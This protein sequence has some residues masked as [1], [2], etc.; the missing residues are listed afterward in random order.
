MS[1]KNTTIFSKKIFFSMVFLSLI[2]LALSVSS[3]QIAYDNG[4]K[5]TDL[6]VSNNA[7]AVKIT[8]ERTGELTSIDAYL[9]RSGG[10]YFDGFVWAYAMNSSHVAKSANLVSVPNTGAYSWKNYDAIPNFENSSDFYVGIGKLMP[11]AAIT[12]GSDTDSPSGRSETSNSMFDPSSYVIDNSN[13]YMIRANFHYYPTVSNIAITPNPTN[14]NPL[15]TA[16]C[17]AY[18]STVKKAHYSVDNGADWIA[19]NPTDGTW[20]NATEEINAIIPTGTL[21]DGSHNIEIRCRDNDNYFTKPL[22]STSFFIDRVNPNTTISFAPPTPNGNGWYNSPVVFNLSATD[23]EPSSGIAYSEYLLFG[24]T[25]Q[26]WTKETTRTISNNGTTRIVY[27][28]AD[29]AGNIESIAGHVSQ[30]SIDQI[31][32]ST[33]ILNPFPNDY[34]NGTSQTVSWTASTDLPSGI[35]YYNIY[36]EINETGTF[37]LLASTTDTWYID[38]A[39]AD[40]KYNYYITAVDNAGNE[41][42][43]SNQDWFAVDMSNPSEPFMAALPAYTGNAGTV[44]LAWTA[45]NDLNMFPSGINSYELNENAATTNVGNTTAYSDAGNSDATTHSYQTRALDNSV[46]PNYSNWSNTETTTID[47]TAPV[48]THSLSPTLPNGNNGWYVSPVIVTLTANDSGSGITRTYYCIDSTNTCIPNLKYSAVPFVVSTEEGIN[49]ARYYSVDKVNNTEPTNSTG[50]F[51][52]DLTNPYNQSILLDGEAAYN[53]DSTVDATMNIGNDDVS[54][55]S[56]C[57]LSWDNGAT[58]ENIGLAASAGPHAYADGT[59]IAQYKCF[60]NAGNESAIVQ[61]DIIVDTNPPVSA[62]T[63]PDNSG[64]VLKGKIFLEGTAFDAVSGVKKVQIMVKD[65][66]D[67]VVL[68]WADA[69]G[70]DNWSYYWNA[71]ALTDGSYLIKS[72]A[73]DNAGL[74]EADANILITTMAN[75]S[76]YMENVYYENAGSKHVFV[77]GFLDLVNWNSTVEIFDALQGLSSPAIYTYPVTTDNNAFFGQDIDASNW[78]LNKIYTARVTPYNGNTIYTQFDA[79]YYGYQIELLNQRLQAAD[80]NIA[81]LWQDSNNQQQQINDLNMEIQNIYNELDAIN[82]QLSDLN[83]DVTY[84]LNKV[85][86]LQNQID[87]LFNVLKVMNHATINMFYN[88]P[89][90]KLNVWG[91]AA[92]GTLGSVGLILIPVDTN[93]PSYYYTTTVSGPNNA[94]QFTMGNGNPIDTSILEK[95]SYNVFVYMLSNFRPPGA[96]PMYVVGTIFDNLAIEELNAE[97]TALENTVDMLNTGNIQFQY[98]STSNNMTILGEVPTTAQCAKTWIYTASGT[99]LAHAHIGVSENPTGADYSLTDNTT[100][101]PQETL[102]IIVQFYNNTGCHGSPI[103][104]VQDTFDSLLSEDLFGFRDITA[105]TYVTSYYVNNIQ[106]PV[107]FALKSDYS[108]WFGGMLYKIEY[109][110]NPGE[111][112]NELE[113]CSYYPEGIKTYKHGNIEL[114]STGTKRVQLRAVRCGPMPH[115]EDY[116][117]YTF[118]IRHVDLADLLTADTT[119]VSPLE[120][121]DMTRDY[122]VGS[123][124]DNV[125][126]TQT[127]SVPLV[128]YLITNTTPAELRCE[129][130]YYLT[131][132]SSN[133]VL[134]PAYYDALNVSPNRWDCNTDRGSQL[135]TAQW[136]N[137]NYANG[138]YTKL[139]VY[140]RLVATPNSYADFNVGIDNEKPSINSITP[141]EGGI[142]NG[143]YTWYA[144]VSDNLSGIAQVDFYLIEKAGYEYCKQVDENLQCWIG[145]GNIIWPVPNVS[146]NASIEPYGKFYY[147]LNTLN[148]PDGD[149]NVGFGATDIAGNYF[150]K[151][152]DPIIDNTKPIINSVAIMPAG[153]NIRGTTIVIS[154]NVSDNLSG[155]NSVWAT[156]TRPGGAIDSLPLAGTEPNYTA[157]YVTDT[158][159]PADGTYIVQINA[160]DNATNNAVGYLTSFDLNY[161]YAIDINLSSNSVTQGDSVTITGKLTMDDSTII[162]DYT[163]ELAL[164]TGTVTIDVNAITGEFS[165]VLNTAGIATGTHTITGKAIAPNSIVSTSTEQ[166]TINAL[167]VPTPTPLATGGSFGG[168]GGGGGSSGG[169]L[170][171]TIDGNCLNKE[172]IITVR[173]PANNLVPDATIAIMKNNS[174]IAELTS[175]SSGKAVFIAKEAGKYTFNARKG[176]ASSTIYSLE[177]AECTETVETPQAQPETEK[178]KPSPAPA[179][180]TTGKQG[181]DTS[182]APTTMAVITP[183]GFFGLETGIGN[184]AMGILVIIGVAW[185]G[186]A[187]KAGL[188]KQGKK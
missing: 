121:S 1:K 22:A 31:A 67:N 168:G 70:T 175:D 99:F 134:P 43:A 127:G 16:T 53:T 139:R 186:F 107:T 143:I 64:I 24:V 159:F 8:P 97:L 140:N 137:L 108:S 74:Q 73:E 120:N 183:T 167:P 65:S 185:F 179:P 17:T 66:L 163:V 45:S 95:K 75:P 79:L 178:P 177:V 123:K 39:L 165:Y 81:A 40:N 155:V 101:W 150:Y 59:Q 89:M 180:N 115:T 176:I 181:I 91:A 94:Y 84:L 29:N 77:Y 86:Q 173:N 148:F 33:P 13:N 71:S 32:P 2:I 128:S 27:R 135:S 146:F 124:A 38:N 92:H 90:Q 98:N 50:A 78:D 126:W 106:V 154:A 85:Q 3:A 93:S 141:D 4:T 15:V 153:S 114:D 6:L 57:E 145:D 41:S 61:D 82:Q 20:D 111:G 83:S 169:S 144:D 103:G 182:P 152:V 69:N 109:R 18:D 112:W 26:S 23:A 138:E 130:N 164:P 142:M 157:N 72:R 48:T 133:P 174:Q 62:I 160:V 116:T 162:G 55:L 49:Y 132:T 149:Y 37:A 166:L 51:Y 88:S 171:L 7:Y 60:D 58:W 118:R 54:G 9:K 19:M 119:I 30:I 147:D 10:N 151:E 170:I 34:I 131:E 161:S 172:I 46:G 87:F 76:P 125:Y 117:S 110:T 158:S 47:I 52:I 25:S 44:D 129:V 136:N 188:G 28:S 42:T 96:P 105:S 21:A 56:Y 113:G 35:D 11:S 12:L 156:I 80:A 63:R 187:Y 14:T 36:K 102:N 184:I 5:E 104:T 100:G 122:P 68:D